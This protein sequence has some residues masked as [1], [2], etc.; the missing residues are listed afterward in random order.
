MLIYGGPYMGLAGDVCK[1]LI[2]SAIQAGEMGQ[3]PEQWLEDQKRMVPGMAEGFIVNPDYFQ[4]MGMKGR[5]LGWALFVSYHFFKGWKYEGKPM[6]TAIRDA[7][8]AAADQVIGSFLYHHG[9]IS[10][11]GYAPGHGPGDKPVE[12]EKPVGPEKPV[13]EHGPG[14]KPPVGAHPP[15]EG[16]TGGKSGKPVAKPVVGEHG[17]VAKPVVGEHGPG[18]AAGGRPPEAPVA[19]HEPTP[20]GADAPH[21]PEA[22]VAG[23]EPPVPPVAPPVPPKPG[24]GAGPTPPKPPTGKEPPKPKPKDPPK[25]KPKDP[26]PPPPPPPPPVPPMRPSGPKTWQEARALINGSTKTVNGRKVIDPA[27]V[28]NVMRNPDA[29]RK[30]KAE[31]PAAWATFHEG[32]QKIYDAHDADLK[33]WIENNV[34]EAKGQN[35]EVRTVGTPTGVDRDF[36]AGRMITDPVTGQQKFIEIKKEAWKSQSDKIFSEKTGGPS[37]PAGAAKWAKDHQQLQTDQYHAEASVD[38]ADQGLVQDPRTGEW[39]KTQFPQSNLELTKHG[40]STLIDPEGLGKTYETKVAEAYHAGNKGDAFAQAG[41][42]VKTLEGVRDGYAEQHYGVKELP[43]KVKAG[44]D[45][46]KEVEAGT[47]TPAQAEAKIKEMK[48][49]SLPDFMEKI[50]GQFGAFK[51]ARKA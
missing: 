10:A 31:D 33:S 32:R 51:W 1:G 15:G 42:A 2:I 39:R 36:R 14:E 26:P 23:H 4:A 41:K 3:S 30:L 21:A 11:K 35:I 27:V 43:P 9:H 37:D 28:E 17:P 44:I 40:Q 48:L 6:L 47:M 49:G 24:A 12:P 38:M 29:M 50:S 18:E 13:S 16:G 22:P 46:I 20:G 25:P 7:G 5:A 45:A 34:P 8:M 19:G